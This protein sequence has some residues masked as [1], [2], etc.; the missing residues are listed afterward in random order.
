MNNNSIDIEAIQRQ[1]LQNIRGDIQQH[2]QQQIRK[3]MVEVK[4]DLLGI[5]E[6]NRKHDDANA[7]MANMENQLETLLKHMS[8]LMIG[9]GMK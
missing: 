7:R 3:E 1:I 8:S 9:G 4:S 5:K 6:L 2:I